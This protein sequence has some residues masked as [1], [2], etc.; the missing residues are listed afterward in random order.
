[1][2]RARGWSPD[3]VHFAVL[4]GERAAR[5]LGG[6]GISG[7]CDWIGRQQMNTTAATEMDLANIDL[8]A[9]GAAASPGVRRCVAGTTFRAN[10]FRAD[11]TAAV[12]KTNV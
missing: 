6:P 2:P 4:P 9:D 8:A 5:D 11:G 12:T 10:V 1:M 7:P 3:A